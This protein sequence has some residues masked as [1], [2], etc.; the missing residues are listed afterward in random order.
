MGVSNCGVSAS[1]VPLPPKARAEG[2][3]FATGFCVP[4]E[5]TPEAT[6]DH[7][8]SRLTGPS[9]KFS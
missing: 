2:T 3:S 8:A 9:K 7:L 5:R 4:G 6:T 1:F